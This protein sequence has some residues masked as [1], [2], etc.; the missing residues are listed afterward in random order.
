LIYARRFN[1]GLILCAGIVRVDIRYYKRGLYHWNKC[2]KWDSAISDEVFTIK[3]RKLL[4][5]AIVR[6]GTAEPT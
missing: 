2:D 1:P 4:K 6:E 3:L 5:K